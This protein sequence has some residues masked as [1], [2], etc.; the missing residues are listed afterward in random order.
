MS[1]S[2]KNKFSFAI[3]GNIGRRATSC[4]WRTHTAEMECVHDSLT[5]ENRREKEYPLKDSPAHVALRKVV[6]D[7]RFLNNIPYSLTT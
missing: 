7:K 6:F 5:G 4:S 3:I 1:V 2:I